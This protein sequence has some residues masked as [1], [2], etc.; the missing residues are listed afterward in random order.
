MATVSPGRA[1]LLRRAVEG[2]DSGAHQRTS[3][4]GRQ[5]VGNEGEGVGGGDDVVGV[6]AVVG[7]AGDLGVLAE[8]EVA[9]AAGLAVVAVAAMPAEAD[10]LAGL[11]DGDIG[12]DGVDDSGDF[13]AG[14]RGYAMPGKRPSLV[15][16]S[17]WQMPQAW[18]R[19][20]TWPG[21]GSG[22]SFWTNSKA[23]LGDGT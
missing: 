2:G 17:L 20:R 23:A 9:A 12:A 11:E 13:V 10:A 1:P 6:A 15:T 3:V 21:P 14:A 7:D 19:M 18:T 4:D 8:D 16:T 5:V 22:N